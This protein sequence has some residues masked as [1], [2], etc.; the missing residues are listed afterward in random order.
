MKSLSHPNLSDNFPIPLVWKQPRFGEDYYE[1]C[2]EPASDTLYAIL[3]R[4]KRL[5]DLA[6]A[7]ISV[8]HQDAPG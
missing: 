7:C 8:V 5:S 1:L 4:L 3:Y 2:D 6:I